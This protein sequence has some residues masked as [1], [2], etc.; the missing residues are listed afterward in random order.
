[1]AQEETQY[2]Q[3]EHTGQEIDDAVEEMQELS[4]NYYNKQEVNSRFTEERTSIDEALSEFETEVNAA[5]LSKADK[6]N[7]YTKQQVDAALTGKAD[8]S[9]T[10]TKTAVNSMLSQLR[11]LV[12]GETDTKISALGTVMHYCGDLEFFDSTERSALYTAK[13][14]A[15]FNVPFPFTYNGATYPMNTFVMVK[16]DSNDP[17]RFSERVHVFAPDLS[18]KVDKVAGKGLSANDYTTAE[19][20]KL[21]ALPTSSELNTT[22]G[23]KV[24]NG[25]GILALALAAGFTY[26]A[27]TGTYTHRFLS[28]YDEEGVE[29]D[30]YMTG[31]TET[32]V[33]KILRVTARPMQRY[34]WWPGG[35]TMQ[36]IKCTAE[37]NGAFIYR[38]AIDTS[39]L[40]HQQFDLEV[41][42]PC[43]DYRST[44][45]RAGLLTSNATSMFNEC[46]NLR[47]TTAIDVKDCTSVAKM[48]AGCSALVETRIFGLNQDISFADSPNLSLRSLE[49]LVEHAANTEAI[50]VL[51]HPY[52]YDRLEDDWRE[53]EEAAALKNI[54]LATV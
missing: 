28:K 1:M 24:D 3:S 54:S 39:S 37:I 29:K 33:A 34:G 6:S 20:N 25:K 48:F 17:S 2:Y 13:K 15:V 27:Q 26:D 51:V 43:D 40:C 5:I 42:W 22:L 12:N 19:K 36:K 18:G 41:F 11:T 53:L 16:S 49:Y 31:L 10:Y 21:A 14:G 9:E 46:R 47:R 44:S 38:P 35:S 8:K 30:F 7:T 50:T 4:R 52:V 32:D 45:G 23:G